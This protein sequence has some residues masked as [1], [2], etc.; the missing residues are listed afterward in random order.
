MTL[1]VEALRAVEEAS[2]D[3]Q[4]LQSNMDTVDEC[5]AGSGQSQN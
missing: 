2:L 5:S 4:Q 3:D 1:T